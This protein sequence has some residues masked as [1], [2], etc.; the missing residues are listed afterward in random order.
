MGK[1]YKNQTALKFIADTDTDL[2]NA[3]EKRIKYLKPS[4]ATGHWIATAEGN[5][6]GGLISYTVNYATT[7][8][9]AGEWKLWSWVKFS[10]GR[11]APGEAYSLMI[12]EEG[13]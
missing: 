5:P 10:D 3:V 11:S 8:D 6:T 2:T 1:I 9:E 12:Y 13:E 4:S 7:I